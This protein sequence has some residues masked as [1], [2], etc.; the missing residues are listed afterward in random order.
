MEAVTQNWRLLTRDGVDEC[1]LLRWVVGLVLLAAACWAGGPR[2]P[3]RS[4][5]RGT[6]TAQRVGVPVPRAGVAEGR[7]PA[8]DE[9]IEAR[10]TLL[11]VGPARADRWPVVETRATQRRLRRV[12]AQQDTV[13]AENYLN[14]AR[15]EVEVQ[16]QPA[17]RL[18]Q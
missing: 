10:Q 11:T 13:P 7:L 5:L 17:V 16:D 8:P 12:A 14:V 15:L 6:V 18:R 1:S 2:M 4:S 9:G 3:D